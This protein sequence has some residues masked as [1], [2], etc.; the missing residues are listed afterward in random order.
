MRP[1]GGAVG[2]SL[3]QA[4]VANDTKP[5]VSL[6]SFLRHTCGAA[7]WVLDLHQQLRES[8]EKR[9]FP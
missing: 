9:C 7:W 8:R 6:R 4:I 5:L 1:G 3:L 2:L